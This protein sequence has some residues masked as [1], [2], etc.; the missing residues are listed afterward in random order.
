MVAE[1]FENS[2]PGLDVT[3]GSS[4]IEVRNVVRRFG[5][6]EVLRGVS[7]VVRRGEVHALLGPNGAGKT[8][9]L[10]ILT[11]LLRCH[12]G[13]VRFLG[14]PLEEVGLRDY[15]RTF[16]FVP[17]GDR[18]FYL[19]MSGVENLLFF[20]RLAGLRRSEAMV[21]AR[22][23]L[24]EVGLQGVGKKMVGLYSH[25]MQK[26][27]SVARALLMDPPALFVDEATHDLD[28]EGAQRV[29]ELIAA[30]A[31]RGTSVVWAT[32]RLDEIRAFADRVTLLH[33]GH[34]RFDGT[35]HQLIAAD[36]A[37]A[38]V[39]RIGIGGRSSSDVLAIARS[40]IGAAGRISMHDES[41]AKHYVL[42]LEGHDAIGQAVWSLEES[43]LNVISCR[44]ERSGIE[45]AF[46][47]LTREES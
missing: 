45:G 41:E 11:G 1:E 23:C 5:E 9:L 33:L 26:R 20:G 2:D 24:D 31:E 3:G 8:T 38:Y 7:L 30:R 15:R 47:R 25:G 32:Q 43:G 39:L 37:A 13:E 40:A 17:S 29:K 12:G 22:E 21:R 34:V 16:G 19:R 46:L 35:V 14:V 27:L 18:S 6:T 44:E 42:L 28:P 10:R 36:T 4:I